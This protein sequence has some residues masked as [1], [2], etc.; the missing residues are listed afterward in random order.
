MKKLLAIA[1]LL[2]PACA[3]RPAVSGEPPS[4]TWSG[5]YD[6]GSER[7]ES[8]SVDLQWDG[9]NLRGAVHA[10]P[11]SLPLTKASYK[12]DTGDIS[13]E[14]DAEGNRGQIVHYTIEGKVTGNTMTGTWT[15]DGQRG[16]FRVTKQ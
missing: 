13:M 3:A 9:T 4:G 6:V 11:R 1:L 8:I 5:D 12:P 10:G 16:D 7:R 14:F 15:H 2:L